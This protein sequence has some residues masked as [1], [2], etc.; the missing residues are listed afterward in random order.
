MPFIKKVAGVSVS[1]KSNRLT[2]LFKQVAK[3]VLSV[4]PAVGIGATASVGD[5]FKSG[6]GGGGSK[7]C[8]T[9]SDYYI[10]CA[11]QYHPIIPIGAGNEVTIVFQDG[12]QLQSIAEAAN[13]NSHHQ[14][15]SL[16]NIPRPKEPLQDQVIY[17]A[18]QMLTSP[19]TPGG[20]P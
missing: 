14:S 8:S 4:M 15:A 2:R 19:V 16:A 20:Q 10:K 3:K 12:F 11:E 5:V 9:L 13:K 17:Q 6:M 1:K 18:N 7:A